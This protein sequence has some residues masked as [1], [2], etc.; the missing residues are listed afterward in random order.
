MSAKSIL[1]S[2]IW[3][4]CSAPAVSEA[5]ML[6]SDCKPA[7][8]VNYAKSRTDPKGFWRSAMADIYRAVQASE[9]ASRALRMDI[10][11]SRVENQLNEREMRSLGI[12]PAQDPKADRVI[13]ETE[14]FL[15]RQDAE[16]VQS[17]RAWAV[18]CREYVTGQLAKP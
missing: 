1:F 14:V 9:D 11:R 5:G 17:T 16:M 12:I 6:N 15:L 4:L 3:V 8:L 7:G 10:Q 2:A 18:K 13:A